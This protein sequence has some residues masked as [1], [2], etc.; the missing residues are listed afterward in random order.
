MRKA[1]RWSIWFWNITKNDNKMLLS[2]I[3]FS[4]GLFFLNCG[5]VAHIIPVPSLWTAAATGFHDYWTGL[6]L[7]GGWLAGPSVGH[8]LLLRYSR[9][10]SIKWR[11]ASSTA[12]HHRGL[13]LRTLMCDVYQGWNRYWW[14]LYIML[15]TGYYIDNWILYWLWMDIGTSSVSAQYVE[16]GRIL[17]WSV[18]QGDQQKCHKASTDPNV[19]RMSR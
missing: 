16:A 18:L 14:G 9:S 11:A 4:H 5:Q 2:L 15:I 19:P 13:H 8:T 3:V 12:K 6:G 17:P 1:N 10:E 7:R